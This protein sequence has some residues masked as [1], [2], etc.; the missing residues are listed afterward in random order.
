MARSGA[1][2]TGG[3][4]VKKFN[5]EGVDRKGRT[6]TGSTRADSA[7]EVRAQLKQFGFKNIRITEDTTRAREEPSAQAEEAPPDDFV[8]KLVD[9][10]I[11]VE[12]P[13]GEEEQEEGEW[14]RA[15]VFARI[16]RYRRRE[17]TVTAIIIVVLIAIVGPYIF[18][19]MTKIEAPQP[20]IITSSTSEMLSFKDVYVKDDYLVF[21]VF[22]RTWN[23]NVRV[24]IR[25]WDVF[26]NVVAAGT[27]RLGFIGEHYGASP[28]KSGTFKLKKTRFYE[29]IQLVV[30]GDEGK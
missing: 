22:S 8:Q 2:R 21:V 10:D 18:R 14:R 24:D 30:T 16:R 28:E 12:Q 9:G 17:N 13:Y 1:G 5:Y 7:D 11:A 23:G 15:E 3:L 20:R 26:D 25:A 27:A 29:K 6:G 19:R 4:Q